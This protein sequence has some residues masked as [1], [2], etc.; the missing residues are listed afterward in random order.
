[1]IGRS[2]RRW[3]LAIPAMIAQPISV[4]T[5]VLA[6]AGLL[7]PMKRV[8]PTRN[9]GA[10]EHIGPGVLAAAS[11]A[12]LIWA[13]TVVVTKF[14][15]GEVDAIVVGLMRTVLAALLTAPLVFALGLRLPRGG[16]GFGL[17]MVSSMGGFVA[18]PILF[19]LGIIYTTASHAALIMAALPI[20]TGLF[21][22]ISER[23][24]P[25][26]RWWIGVAVA[27]VGE[28]ILVYFRLGLEGGGGDVLLGDL[29]I[30]LGCACSS[31]GYIGGARLARTGVSSIAAAF[32]GITIGGLVA[33]PVLAWR[34]SRVDWLAV[35]AEGW[36]AMIYLALG[37]TI[38]AYV[39]WYWAL[40]RGGIARV[41]L[42]QFVQP[43]I[44][45]A[46]A[47][48]LLGERITVPLLVAAAIIIGGVIIAQRPARVPVAAKVG[49]GR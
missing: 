36:G 29:L 23:R 1:M 19:S 27:F 44:T 6:P 9:I 28:F 21:A 14:V 15:V 48:V 37:S 26:L 25:A 3:R 5:P 11:G 12:V 18:F 38:L 43:V 10:P 22:A 7:I 30:L 46:L 20:Y 49:G 32:W 35:S 34:E 40:A 2:A 45:L 13:A 42:A 41:G 31:F 17:L 33:L 8:S 4:Y 47:A 24:E 39:L 16:A